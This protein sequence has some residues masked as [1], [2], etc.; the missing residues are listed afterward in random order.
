MKFKVYLF[1]TLFVVSLGFSGCKDDDN[2]DPEPQP[3]SDVLPYE[4]Y[5]EYKYSKNR[6]ITGDNYDKSL[7]VRCKNGIFVGWRKDGI[8]HFYGIPYAQQPFGELRWR[9]PQPLPESNTVYEAY[10]FAHSAMQIKVKD[11]MAS[12]YDQGEDCLALNVW[13]SS[14]DAS[15]KRPVMFYVHGGA[16]NLGG[17]SDPLYNA[18]KLVRNHPEVVVVTINYRLNM[19]GHL[20]TRLF[21]DG[22]DEDK[23]GGHGNLATLDQL[24]AL[25]WVRENI[26]AFG[27]DPENITVFGESAG[28]CYTGL[29]AITDLNKDTETGKPMIKNVIRQSFGVN[30]V[31]DDNPRLPVEQF[32]QD[33]GYTT[34]KDLEELSFQDLS[35]V[36][37]MASTVGCG[38]GPRNDGEIIPLDPVRAFE[39]G[40]AADINML[41]GYNS[42]EADYFEDF[43]YFP[44][45][46][47][48]NSL[49]RYLEKGATDLSSFR[50]LEEQ[51][52]QIIIDEYKA[53]GITIT[54]GDT[55]VIKEL[56]NDWG[57]FTSASI[58]AQGQNKQTAGTGKAYFY[59]FDYLSD[60]LKKQGKGVWHAAEVP[61]IFESVNPHYW[62]GTGVDLEVSRLLQTVWTTFAKTGDPSFTETLNGQAFTVKWPQYTSQNRD[63]VKLDL[64]PGVIKDFH[65]ERTEIQEKLLFMSRTYHHSEFMTGMEDVYLP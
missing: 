63:V 4:G 62:T 49:E 41:I 6:I 61:Y 48:N 10:H 31:H 11:E 44:P 2:S 43:P 21:P 30:M 12:Y 20:D 55:R 16:F 65:K 52:Y 50:Q 33:L 54:K 57:F 7:A 36:W 53:K 13:T 3:I 17:G 45:M 51:Y 5:E 29:L 23:Y 39:E 60:A 15:A 25:K 1:S 14:L 58:E 8:S 59:Y 19:L 22:T 56:Y 35:R 47:Q 9:K 46:V 38:T 32:L 64:E 27:G 28:S 40:K 18:R 34:M 42:E 37:E 26:T 24:A